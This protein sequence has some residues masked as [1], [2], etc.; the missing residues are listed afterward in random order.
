M[1][2]RGLPEGWPRPTKVAPFFDWRVPGPFVQPRATICPLPSP[3]TVVLHLS[4]PAIL[5]EQARRTRARRKRAPLTHV[6][7][8]PSRCT[9]HVRSRR[10][11]AVKELLPNDRSCNLQLFLKNFEN[12]CFPIRTDERSVCRPIICK[13]NNREINDRMM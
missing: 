13:G 10:Y 5:K 12:E 9:Y 2:G 3:A 7:Y 11:S 6:V 4:S 1:R 8:L